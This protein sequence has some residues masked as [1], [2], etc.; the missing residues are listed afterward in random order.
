MSKV[1]KC[2][3]HVL[4]TCTEENSAV[5]C[6]WPHGE[7]VPLRV[8]TARPL[9]GRGTNGY[10]YEANDLPPRIFLRRA[11]E[12]LGPYQLLNFLIQ[13]TGCSGIAITSAWHTDV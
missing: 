7:A 8:P 12:E 10:S 2:S 4:V 3:H 6:R 13:A 1:R 9:S 5:N 11:F